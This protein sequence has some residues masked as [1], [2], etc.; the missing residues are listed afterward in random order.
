MF[1]SPLFSVLFRII[2]NFGI[3]SSPT[4]D[5]GLVDESSQTKDHDTRKTYHHYNYYWLHIVVLFLFVEEQKMKNKPIN[6][7]KTAIMGVLLMGSLITSST[8]ASEASDA[9]DKINAQ[10]EAGFTNGKA[11]TIADVYT[12]DAQILPPNSKIITGY[13]AILAFWQGAIDMGITSADLDTIEQD[14]QGDT[15]IE[16]GKYVLR[17]ESDNVLDEG[18]YIVVWKKRNAGW[19]YFRDMW[20]SGLP[21]N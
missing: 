15:A 21:A 18:K 12:Q 8:H 1:E 3:S 14:E 20:S 19:K 9:I 11:K 17:G 10:F 6:P 7:L 2:F 13:D 5:Q 4:F 16:I